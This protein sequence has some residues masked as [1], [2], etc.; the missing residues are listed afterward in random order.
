MELH[1]LAAK[2]VLA[3]LIGALTRPLSKGAAAA[4]RQIDW[5]SR[6]REYR[7]RVISQLNRVRVL[8][9][10][11]EISLDQ[12]FTDVYVLTELPSEKYFDELPDDIRTDEILRRLK[13]RASKNRQK[14]DDFIVGED[15]LYLLGSPGAGK[16]TLMR[17]IAIQAA[18]GVLDRI[19]V[20]LAL[21]EIY[22]DGVSIEKQLDHVL[23]VGGVPDPGLLITK[24]LEAGALILLFDGLDEIP[25]A[26]GRRLNYLRQIEALSK[27]YPKCRVVISCRT[28]ASSYSIEGFKYLELAEFDQDQQAAFLQR[29]FADDPTAHERFIAMWREGS[30]LALRDLASSPLLLTLLCLAYTS[31]GSFPRKKI[32]LF[33]DALN[34]LVYH[35]DT[36][37]GVVREGAL[38]GLEP[39]RK[40][41]LLQSMAY[42]TFS[43]AEYVFEERVAVR[44]L[45]RYLD[46]LP[47]DG[48]R[49]FASGD[50]VRELVAN[51]G[52]IVERATRLFSFSHLSIHEYLAA[53]YLHESASRDEWRSCLRREVVT[54]DRWREVLVNL[55]ALKPNASEIMESLVD[56][57][58]TL[59][60]QS[61]SFFDLLKKVRAAVGSGASQGNIAL[62]L[63]ARTPPFEHRGFPGGREAREKPGVERWISA[64]GECQKVLDPYVAPTF[65]RR[66]H[67]WVYLLTRD[68]VDIVDLLRD[69]PHPD[70]ALAVLSSYFRLL[71]FI[72]EC[73]VVASVSGSRNEYF[74][75][76]L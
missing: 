28:A 11:Q 52:V 73:A 69:D 13:E 70:D 76:L 46:M 47:P 68:D 4:W 26:Q 38:T 41:H 36:S 45:Q 61:P 48:T 8:G 50:M 29:W 1:D 6:E 17:H 40:D 62:A 72:V 71:S 55:A 24:L 20:Y 23:N 2:H 54:E 59:G 25:P 10:S 34:A 7:L 30:N 66:F 53:C 9:K 5:I 39:R 22:Q 37:R 27:Q 19:P 67:C 3:P 32:D 75:R 18:R 51:H 43:R 21:R 63:G 65:W 31:T 12:V 74:E 15:R 14:I 49:I 64:I 60:R 42:H 56:A 58:D 33:R 57:A 44:E 35:W 16:T